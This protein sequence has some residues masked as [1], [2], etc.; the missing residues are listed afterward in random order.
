MLK[1]S[2]LLIGK[3]MD[4]SVFCKKETLETGKVNVMKTI[5][6]IEIN[7]IGDEII[8]YFE[9]KFQLDYY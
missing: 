9:A 4:F 8:F 2:K 7:R 5:N 1:V 6:K 3:K